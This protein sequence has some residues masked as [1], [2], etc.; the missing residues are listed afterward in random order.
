MSGM[1]DFL[2]YETAEG[3]LAG[4]CRKCGGTFWGKGADHVHRE[5]PSVEGLKILH[6]FYE[7]EAL[8]ALMGLPS[9]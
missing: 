6:A 8:A 7:D 5:G 9:Q 2:L 1:G 3:D 4:V